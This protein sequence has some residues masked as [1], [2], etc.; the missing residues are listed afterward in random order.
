MKA[1][2]CCERWTAVYL[3]ESLQ[4]ANGDMD[5]Q[6]DHTTTEVT[7]MCGLKAWESYHRLSCLGPA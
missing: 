7:R 5:V 6:L 2:R 3:S 1:L 4:L